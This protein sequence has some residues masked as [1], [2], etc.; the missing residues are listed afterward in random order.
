ME[1]GTPLVIVK[2]AHGGDDGRPFI[3]GLI[4]IVFCLCGSCKGKLYRWVSL[5]LLLLEFILKS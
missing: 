3:S 2:T 4:V 1:A 5:W